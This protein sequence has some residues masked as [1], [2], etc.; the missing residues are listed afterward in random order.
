MVSGPRQCG[1]ATRRPRATIRKLSSASFDAILRGLIW[2]FSGPKFRRRRRS[3]TKRGE[4]SKHQDPSSREA[5]REAPRIKFQWTTHPGPLLRPGWSCQWRRGRRPQVHNEVT[6][7]LELSINRRSVGA[8]APCRLRFW[9]AWTAVPLTP[10]LSPG[11]GRTSGSGSRN[12]GFMVAMRVSRTLGL[13]IILPTSIIL[14]ATIF[15]FDRTALL[16]NS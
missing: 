14:R 9:P 15:A 4:S 1:S 10:T 12:R 8:I 11:R 16:Y 7:A 13:P 5:P 6:R 3:R 2:T